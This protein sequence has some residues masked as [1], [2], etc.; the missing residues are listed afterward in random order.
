[1][2]LSIADTNA[3]TTTSDFWN[4]V[5]YGGNLGL[6]FGNGYFSGSAAPSAIYTFNPYFSA[7]PGLNFSYTKEEFYKATLV[8]GSLIALV[9]PYPYV[10]FSAE[11]EELYVSQNIT[12]YEPD[13]SREFWNTALF[14]GLGYRTGPVTVGIRYNVLYQADDRVYADAFQPFLRVYF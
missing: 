1:M 14:L 3:Q 11:L 12:Y 10:Q 2:L 13:Q 7:G 5:S 6:S 8:G 4:R 9:N